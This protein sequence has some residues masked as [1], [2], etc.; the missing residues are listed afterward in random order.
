MTWDQVTDGIVP[1]G[2]IRGYLVYMAND[3]AGQYNLYFNGTDRPLIRTWIASGLTPG[4]IYRFKVSAIVYNGEGALSNEFLT[5]SCV[6]PSKMMG[7]ERI[8]STST[9]MT[10]RWKAPEE[11]GGCTITGYAVYRNDGE[12][13]TSW[14]EVN[15]AMDSNVRDRPTLLNMIVTSFPVA[16]AGKEFLF[17]VVAFNE[18][19]QYSSE[20]SGY[21]LA[22]K[23][24]AP[25]QGPILTFQSGNKLSVRYEPL[26]TVPETGGSEVL[27][28]NLQ[29]DDGMGGEFKSLY[30]SDSD[31]ITLNTMILYHSVENLIRGR[32]YGFRYRTRNHYGWSD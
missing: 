30:G 6:I 26:L 16:S 12:G 7:P 27:G 8:I 31:A 18:M 25:L 28:Y 2:V 10:L 32:R 22:S 23:P 29:M 15:T 4:M 3:T 14:T 5:Y 13:G 17:K 24:F 19:G 21:V 1:G 11:D 9:T 20:T